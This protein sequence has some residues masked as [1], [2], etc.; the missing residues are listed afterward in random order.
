MARIIVGGRQPRND[1]IGRNC[2]TFQIDVDIVVKEGRVGQNPF[3][4]DQRHIFGFGNFSHDTIRATPLL[5]KLLVHR[6]LSVASSEPAELL[7]IA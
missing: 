1:R 2:G 5:N 7:K 3:Q 4:I 6:D